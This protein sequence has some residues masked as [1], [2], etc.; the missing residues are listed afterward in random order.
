MMMEQAIRCADKDG[1]TIYISLL[2]LAVSL[3]S[4][5]HLQ[6]AANVVR[7]TDGGCYSRSC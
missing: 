7:Q 3:S 4:V 2:G 5:K 1:V 6:K